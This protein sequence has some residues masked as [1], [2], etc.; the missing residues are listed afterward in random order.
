MGETRMRA[1]DRSRRGTFLLRASLAAILSVIGVLALAAL[2]TAGDGTPSKGWHKGKGYS[3]VATCPKGTV[4]FKFEPVVSG[5]KGDGT[6][7]VTITRTDSSAGERFDFTSNLPVTTVYVKGGPKAKRYDYS[8]P[9]TSG[10]GLHAP[11][12]WHSGK[13]YGLSNVV[14]CYKPGSPPPA[15]LKVAIAVFTN[16]MKLTPAREGPS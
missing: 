3:K 12:N 5:T 4:R 10:T 7:S 6:F 11:K 14:F 13:W 8:P 9:V 1:R 15:G 16:E 2:A